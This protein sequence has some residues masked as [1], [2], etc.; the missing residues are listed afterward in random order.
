MNQ[1]GEVIDMKAA[2]C[3]DIYL[4]DLMS[5]LKND[6]SMFWS[7]GARDFTVDNKNNPTMFRMKVS[8]HHHKGFV[9]IFLN[10]MDLFDVYLTTSKNVITDRTEEMG[11]Y[12]DQLAE[13]IDNKIERIAAYK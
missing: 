11:I 9:Y 12:F 7:W 4:P 3:R 6:I 8:G 10:G 5:L 2:S 1:T 13:W